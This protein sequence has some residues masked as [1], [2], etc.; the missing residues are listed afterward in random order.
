MEMVLS[1]LQTIGLG[2]GGTNPA[3]QFPVLFSETDRW[4][5]ELTAG[6]QNINP[7]PNV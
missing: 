4:E 1:V 5:K 6:T 2:V 3:D 7:Q